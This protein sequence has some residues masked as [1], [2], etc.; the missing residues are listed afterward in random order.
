MNEVLR[1]LRVRIENAITRAVVERAD[2]A[3][4]YLHRKWGGDRLSPGVENL[5]PQGLHCS[6][7]AG[8]S[9]V[10]LAPGGSRA[11]VVAL[12]VGASTPTDALEAGEGG[13]HLLGTFKVFMATDGTLHLGKK[14]PDDY[15]ALAS[16]VDAAVSSLR[17]DL[18]TL[19]TAIGTGLTAVGVGA[20]ANGPAGKTAFDGASAA[21]PASVASVASS[22]VKVQS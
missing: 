22:K 20:A 17:Q 1:K 21:V 5:E 8:A 12:G 18:T 4:E 14:D 7:P 6:P 11:G 9:A 2:A 19:K 15:V 16:K 10:L 3:A 13:L